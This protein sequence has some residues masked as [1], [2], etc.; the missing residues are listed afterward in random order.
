VKKRGGKL[1]GRASAGPALRHDLSEDF[2][3]PRRRSLPTNRDFLVDDDQSL[4][5]GRQFGKSDL[6]G[7]T[8]RV[9]GGIPRGWIGRSFVGTTFLL[10]LGATLFGFWQARAQLLKNPRLI[11]ESSSAIQIAGNQHLTRAQLLTVFGEDVDRNLLTIPLEMRRIELESLPWVEHATVMRL[12]PDHIRIAITERKPVAFVR[13]GKQIGLVDAHGVVLDMASDGDGG[14]PV[15]AHYSF[16]VVTGISAQDPLSTR[17]PRMKLFI[18]FLAALG[19]N[20]KN[21]SEV[22]LSSPEDI[23]ALIPDADSDILVHFGGEDFLHRY[24]L[25]EKNLPGWK[26]EFPHLASADMRYE[27]QVVLEMQP[28]VVAR[29]SGAASAEVVSRPVA[30]VATKPEGKKV[31]QPRAAAARVPAAKIPAAKIPAAKIPAAKIP[32]SAVFIPATQAKPAAPKTVEPAR[33]A[34]AVKH[35]EQAFDV[36]AVKKTGV[37][38]RAAKAGQP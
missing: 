32:T 13:Q 20:A 14:A 23:K 5:S 35:L 27:R 34:I 22:D 15:D 1:S 19:E 3:P 2:A 11:L 7:L 8:L 4:T 21:V 28:G 6:E 36:P 33:A 12:L 31:T 17:A 10:A 16:P 38:K 24:E 29:V 18:R 37:G 26:K 25:Y 9:R 30:I